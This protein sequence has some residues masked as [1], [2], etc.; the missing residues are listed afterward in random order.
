MAHPIDGVTRHLADQCLVGTAYSNYTDD[1]AANVWNNSP[2]NVFAIVPVSGFFLLS[3]TLPYPTTP[4][5]PP[6]LLL[7]HYSRFSVMVLCTVATH[8]PRSSVSVPSPLPLFQLLQRPAHELFLL[9]YWR[10]T[11]TPALAFCPLISPHHPVASI[12]LTSSSTPPPPSSPSPP[13]PP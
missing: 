7:S 11:R 4:P 12:P 13:P 1:R 2:H 8:H 3:Y 10:G 6:N 9:W 5:P